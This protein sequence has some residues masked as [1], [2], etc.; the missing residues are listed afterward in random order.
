MILNRAAAAGATLTSMIGFCTLD[1]AGSVMVTA[2]NPAPTPTVPYV[3]LTSYAAS[4]CQGIFSDAINFVIGA[5]TAVPGST[6]FGVASVSGSVR[7]DECTISF[8]I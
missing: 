5:C 3:L 2:P 7:H 4:N 1:N 8:N 6:G